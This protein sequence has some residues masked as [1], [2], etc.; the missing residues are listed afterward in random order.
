MLVMS[1]ADITSI[2]SHSMRVFVT[3]AS[4]HIGSALVPELI[5]NGHEVVG[6]ARSDR[7]AAALEAAGAEGCRGDVDDPDG[8]RKSAEATD[9]VGLLAFKPEARRSGDSQ[10][11][12]SVDPKS[13]EAMG[14]LLQG[15]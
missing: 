12:I 8:L 7:S 3:G 2:G 1:V 11:A 10:S 9:E 5:E 14:A 13:F 4:G 15:L 6:F